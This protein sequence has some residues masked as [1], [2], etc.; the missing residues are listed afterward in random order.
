M[1]SFLVSAQIQLWVLHWSS[2]QQTTAAALL[3]HIFDAVSNALNRG[4]AEDEGS[5]ENG[6]NP[7]ETLQTILKASR[8]KSSC[9]YTVLFFV[10]RQR[11]QQRQQPQL[12]FF[13]QWIGAKLVAGELALGMLKLAIYVE[14][15]TA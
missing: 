5:K 1:N 10:I 9:K 15:A 4:N 14:N 7:S 11:L 3:T 12:H 2:T 8:H 13:L 6:S